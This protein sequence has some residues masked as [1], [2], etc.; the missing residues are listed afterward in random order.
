M[1]KGETLFWRL[2]RYR[3]TPG[4]DAREDRLTEALA[5][6][7]E[8]CNE[9]ARALVRDVFG[10]EIDLSGD[11]T[12]R[13]QQ[14]AGGARRVDIEL[15]FGPEDRPRLRVWFENKVGPEATTP[16]KQGE[17]Y[18]RHLAEPYKGRNVE[19]CFAWILPVGMEIEGDVPEKA[20]RATWQEV[21]SVLREVDE[22]SGLPDND[23]GLTL[24]R[25]F[26][27]HLEEEKLAQVTPLTEKGAD[28]LNGYETALAAM[29]EIVTQARV[30]IQQKWDAPG[31]S[32]KGARGNPLWFYHHY[33]MQKKLDA[34]AWPESGQCWFEWH[35]RPDDA[36]EE[37]QGEAIFAA[38]VVFRVESAPEPRR[39]GEWLDYFHKRHFEYGS[40]DAEYQYLM[41][42]MTLAELARAGSESDLTAQASALA[43]FVVESFE[44][45]YGRPVDAEVLR[46]AEDGAV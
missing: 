32:V 36:R 37:P 44:A 6:T 15:A 46:P 13:T 43:R 45:L 11:I 8:S 31:E 18:M 33:P 35:A 26:V 23:F 9:G 24:T 22:E 5:V 40:G 39:D 41:R 17:Q 25:Q 16:S 2:R 1:A 30:E 10:K 12:V 21:A 29:S 4:R 38:G 34:A 20:R 28:A 19:W 42:Y 14:A 7:L 3:R 27:Q